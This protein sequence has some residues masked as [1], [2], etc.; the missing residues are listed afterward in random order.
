MRVFDFLVAT[1]AL[2]PWLT[3]GISL[4]L[5][6]GGVLEVRDLGIPILALLLAAN[7]RTVW[8]AVRRHPAGALWLAAAGVAGLV[9]ALWLAQLWGA[10]HP[11]FSLTSALWSLSHHPAG[12]LLLL[13]YAIAVRVWLRQPWERS[14][15]VRAFLRLAQ[16]WVRAVAQAP[17][18]CLWSA[19][20][21]VGA[22]LAWIALL[23][24]WAF[25]S[26]GHD[27]GIFTNAIW[28]LTHGNGYVS[29]IK[30]GINLFA[31][32][33]SPLFWL[34]APLFRIAPHPETLIVAQ[35]FG[36]AAGG[37]ALYYLARNPLGREHWAP[38]V[39]PWLYWSYLPLRNANAFDFHPE[40]FMLPLFLWAFVG[41][42]SERPWARGLGLLALVGAL[43]AK[44]SAPVVG[45]G[46]GLAWMLI[47]RRA[48][49]GL[50]LAA[51][52]VAVFFFDVKVVPRLLGSEYAYLG[53]YQRFGGGIGDVLLAPFTQPGFFFSQV[54]DRER[55][56][57]LF[58]T[59]APLG[60]L[61]LF[62]WR[63]ALAALPPY[64]MLFLTEGDQRVATN[65]HYGIEPASALFWALPLGL[66]AFARR[67]GW[68]SAAIWMLVWGVAAHG[69]GELARVQRLHEVPHAAWLD[70][71]LRCLD[72]QAPLA[73]SGT[74]AAQLATRPWVSYP[75]QLERKPSGE[76]VPCVVIDRAVTN[77]PLAD[78]A[79]QGVIAGLPA[80][81]YR[82]VYRCHEFR[83]FELGEAGCLR[84]RPHCE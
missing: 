46:I 81:G 34:L 64:L 4:E 45:A 80:Q 38:A 47:G 66:A 32:H 61:P 72:P 83:V 2:F 59:L 79:V 14:F 22:A 36:L 31:D 62:D 84:C 63:V 65:F 30:D 39:L 52:S 44:E 20:A 27:I 82:E 53:A 70:Q 55:L 54:I 49:P 18:R 8:L 24:H 23:R 48:W 41:F 67:F 68:E 78:A 58:W 7:W 12:L 6:G 21:V 51:A 16:A 28:N 75:D 74:L 15:F 50:A 77:W 60:F 11:G 5:P 33:Q 9:L 19:S 73:A 26:H 43:G 3:A 17:A 29:S 56:I 76:R 35:A 13:F 57:F 10:R 37:P 71:A 25:E 69:P 42:A 40:V 1:L